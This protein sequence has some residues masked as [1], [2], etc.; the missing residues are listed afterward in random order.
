MASRGEA[1]DYYNGA[2]QQGYSQT[3]GQP[4]YAPQQQ[5]PP[6]YQPYAPPPGP[7]DGRQEYGGSGYAGGEKQSFDQAFKIPKP[8][9]NDLWAG[10]L[11]IAVFLGYAATSGI[12]IQGYCELAAQV[13]VVGEC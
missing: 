1:Q 9:Y 11:F 5:Q 3:Q 4:E 2:P 10:L 12:A 8:K 7:P 13:I 6:Q